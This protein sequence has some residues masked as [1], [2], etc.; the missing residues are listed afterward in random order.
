MDIQEVKKIA[1]L[2]RL[3][4]TDEELKRFAGQLGSILG[5]VERL[6]K[7]PLEGVEPLTQVQA[8]SNV[9]RPDEPRPSVD[10]ETV[11]KEA[12]EPSKGFYRV[13]RILE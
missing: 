9:M 13:P 4:L 12:P 3:E 7:L 1:H 11:L 8:L 6:S 2:A 5:Y 10:R